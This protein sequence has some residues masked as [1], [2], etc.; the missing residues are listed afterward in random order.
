M[1]PSV[2]RHTWSI[3]EI[4]VSMS[5]KSGDKPEIVVFAGPNGS[6][7]STIT[8]DEWIKGDYINADDMQREQNLKDIEAADLAERTMYDHLEKGDTF[9]FETVLSSPRK[10]ILL[11]SAK[12]KGYFI[13]GYF[14]LTCD[15]NLNVARVKA[16]A[17]S[18]KHDV[19]EEKVITRYWKALANIPEFLTLCDMCHIY[20]NTTNL[21]RI[22]RRHKNNLTF[23][24]NEFWS[25]ERIN[26][27]VFG[28]PG[29]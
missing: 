12:E 21:F 6:G 23:Y 27:L 28:K 26:R 8:G 13:R 22:C 19:P 2:D 29:K 10:M 5:M 11:R 20:D 16:R 18:G 1:T 15:P 17:I 9:T 24:Q 4:A 25:F 14:I 3:P 7:K